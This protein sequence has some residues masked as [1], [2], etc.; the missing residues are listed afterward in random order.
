[1]VRFEPVLGAVNVRTCDRLTRLCFFFVDTF[2]GGFVFTGAFADALIGDTGTT[3]VP[4]SRH[5]TAQIAVINT[6]VMT[7]SAMVS[8][9]SD[10]AAHFNRANFNHQSRDVEH[11]TGPY[12]TLHSVQVDELRVIAPG[13]ALGEGIAQGAN[14]FV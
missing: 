2:A 5:S 6:A 10:K 8:F 13:T 7:N 4:R 12:V 9:F 11:V 3:L 14:E 1:M